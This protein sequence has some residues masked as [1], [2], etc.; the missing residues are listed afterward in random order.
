MGTISADTFRRIYLLYLLGRFRQGPYGLMRLQKVTYVSERGDSP[1]QPFKY[2]KYFFGQYSDQLDDIKDQLASMGYLVATP[3]DTATV[4]KFVPPGTEKALEINLG[5]N[6]FFVR[7]RGELAY[8]RR[9]LESFSSSLPSLIDRAVAEYGYLKE[10]E[11]LRRC[12]Q[13]PEFVGRKEGDVILDSN[14][15]ESIDIGLPDEEC[16]DLELAMNP[17][18]VVSMTR[19]VAAL[20]ETDVDWTKVREVKTLRT[21]GA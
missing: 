3:L 7:D 20:E 9:V 13:F 1:V 8:Y 5:G 4:L 21:R 6:R 18:F 11:L 10:E 17:R 12:Y 15:P 16:E 14:L 2:K 19:L